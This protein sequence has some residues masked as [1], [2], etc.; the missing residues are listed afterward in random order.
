MTSTPADPA[1]SPSAAVALREPAHRV[2][3]SAPWLW[4][5][6]AVVRVVV[7]V[8][9]AVVAGVLGFVDLAWWAWTLLAVAGAAYVV[10]MPLVRYRIHRWESTETAVYTQ[11]GFLSRERHVAPM[12]KVQTIDMDESA[13][14]RLFGLA[15]VTVT[16]ASAM[17]SLTI[18][19]ID[20]QV[21]QQLVADLT[22]RTEAEADDAT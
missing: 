20:R 18:T 9:A 2:S 11:V 19:A 10:L 13:L 7:V 4:A 6:G 21:A 1:P 8:V 12:S 3:R 17:G 5:I 16:T 14:A 15:T 22:Q